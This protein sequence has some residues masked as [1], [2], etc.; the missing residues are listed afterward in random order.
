MGKRIFLS[1]LLFVVVSASHQVRADCGEK[2]LWLQ[3]LGSGGP[4]LD[5]KRASSGYLVWDKGKARFLIDLGSGS[6]LHFEQSGADTNEL[7]AIMLSHLHVDHTNDLPALIKAAYFTGRSQDLP[8]FGPSGNRLMPSTT[9]YV[10]ALFGEEGAYRYLSSYI[11]GSDSFRLSPNDVDIN[12]VKQQR[13]W[14][15]E[16]S[17][18]T[19]IAV[20]HGPIP[21]LAWRITILDKKVV[22]SGDMNNDKGTLV[23]LAKDADLLVAHNAVP[24]GVIGAGRRLHMPPSE[25]GK[26]ASQAKVQQVLLSHRMKRTLGKEEATLKQISRHYDGAVEFA[27]DMQCI[28]L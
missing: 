14:K 18:I 2:G 11:D 12:T 16:D 27:E 26:I 21:A 24:E 4:E 9:S 28:R 3:V 5:D 25:I 8:L 10:N 13:V 17:E 7:E 19:A 23:K 6:L 22:F 15:R 20:N 1:A